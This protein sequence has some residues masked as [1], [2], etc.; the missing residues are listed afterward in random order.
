M[1]WKTEWVEPDL[2]LTHKRVS[3][4][5]T[6]K[7]GDVDAIQRHYGFTLDTLC[8]EDECNCDGGTKCRNVFDV[9]EIPTWQEPPHPPY[10]SREGDTPE[11]RAAWEKY[12]A[13]HVEEKAIADAVRKA[14]DLGLLPPILKAGS[15]N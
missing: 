14:I 3:V 7:Y 10:L 6:Y 8:G 5:A 11:N 1:P 13:D 2:V 12:H 4:Y 9:R 15:N